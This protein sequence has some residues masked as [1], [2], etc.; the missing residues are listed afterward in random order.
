[1]NKKWNEKTT[2]EKSVSIVSWVALVIWATFTVLERT[3]KVQFAGFVNYITLIIVCVCE[4]FS[5]WN[6]KRSLSYVAIAGIVFMLT[7]VVLEIMLIA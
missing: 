4:A 1:M 3:D 2:L 6:V 7:A 5:F